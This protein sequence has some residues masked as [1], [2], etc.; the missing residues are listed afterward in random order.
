MGLAS[1]G[2]RVRKTRPR[3]RS[4]MAREVSERDLRDVIARSTSRETRSKTKATRSCGR[5]IVQR[6]DGEDTRGREVKL[7]GGSRGGLE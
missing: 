6:D 4:E 7:T 1:S 5:G 3:T 2:F